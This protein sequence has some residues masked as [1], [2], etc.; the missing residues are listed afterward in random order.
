MSNIFN[1]SQVLHSR[2]AHNRKE[3]NLSVLQRESRPEEAIQKSLGEA[4]LAL[5]P[6]AGLDSLFGSLAAAH[7]VFCSRRQLRAGPGVT[8]KDFEMP[9]KILFQKQKPFHDLCKEAI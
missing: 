5:R 8:P 2:L 1:P 6:A 7:P 3:A 9:P 4:P